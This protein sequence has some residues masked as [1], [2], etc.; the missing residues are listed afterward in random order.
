MFGTIICTHLS[1]KYSHKEYSYKKYFYKLFL[2][3]LFLYKL[4]LYKLYLYKLVLLRII[5][6]IDCIQLLYDFLS[7]NIQIIT[8]C[9]QIFIIVPQLSIQKAEKH[10]RV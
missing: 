3:K 7:G 4:Y 10:N 8:Q 5:M 2:H 6:V 9:I 1:K